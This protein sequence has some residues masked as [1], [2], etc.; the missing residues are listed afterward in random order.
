MPIVGG[1]RHWDKEPPDI[2]IL[3]LG[4]ASAAWTRC[5]LPDKFAPVTVATWNCTSLRANRAALDILDHQVLALQEVRMTEDQLQ[6]LAADQRRKGYDM[7]WGSTPSWH[8][9]R[10]GRQVDRQIPGVAI[11]IRTDLRYF[12]DPPS[13]GA[14]KRW[15]DCGRLMSCQILTHQGW[16]H[17]LNVY[18]PQDAERRAVMTQDIIQYMEQHTDRNICLL[19]DFNMDNDSSPIARSARQLRWR[20]MATEGA[21]AVTTWRHTTHESSI[22]SILLSPSIAEQASALQTHDIQ[23]GHLALSCDVCSLPDPE[24]EFVIDHMPA[25]TWH[26]KD[27]LAH[28]EVEAHFLAL[29]EAGRIS[30]AWDTWN[31]LCELCFQPDLHCPREKGKAPRLRLSQ[32][33]QE[34]RHLKG[35]IQRW[36]H[37][38]PQHRADIMT[39]W[40]LTQQ[41]EQRQSWSDWR[42]RMKTSLLTD[43]REYYAWLRGP[44]RQPSRSLSSPEGIT[45]TRRQCLNA[46]KNYWDSIT[47]QGHLYTYAPCVFPMPNSPEDMPHRVHLMKQ[48]IRRTNQHSAM[49]LDDWRAAEWKH[50]PNELIRLFAVLAQACLTFQAVPEQW[51]AVRIALLPKDHADIPTP[52]DYRPL[53]IA[54]VAYRTYAKWMLHLIPDHVLQ[55]LPHECAG[56]IP[57]RAAIL[58]WY[59]VAIEMDIA[60]DTK[61]RPDPAPL[62]G[63]AID[64]Y[65]FFDHVHLDKA[66]Q[67]MAFFGVPKDI[68]ASWAHWVHNHRRYYSFAGTIHPQ[69]TRPTRGIPQGCP[70]SMLA[71]NCIMALWAL[72]MRDHPVKVHT[73]VD[74]RIITATQPQQLQDAV[75][76]TEHF[77][78]QNGFYAR[79]K[80][81]AWTTS[82]E[83]IQISWQDA[84]PL[85]RGMAKYLGLPLCYHTTSP[86]AWFRQLVTRIVD[87]VA[88]ATTAKITGEHADK[89]IVTK[90]LPMLCYSAPIIRPTGDQLSRIRAAFRSLTWKNRSWAAWPLI[91]ALHKGPTFEPDTACFIQAWMVFHR[92]LRQ[93]PPHHLELWRRGWEQAHT[94]GIRTRLRGPLD[95]LR[96]DL[97]RYALEL[98]GEDYLT[99][100]HP[101]TDE[102]IILGRAADKEIKH[103]LTARAQH[104]L[105]LQAQRRKRLDGV[106]HIDVQATTHALRQM[107]AKSTSQQGRA[108]NN[109]D[110]WSCH[111][112]SAIRCQPYAHS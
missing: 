24:E 17:V 54:T 94:R 43:G 56:G 22:D 7:I 82:K 71:A 33:T 5:I 52:A 88:R 36:T 29:C 99:L 91:A 87:T 105:L 93:A 83:P 32:Y 50:M 75:L 68:I 39:D 66:T 44:Q 16:L 72:Q 85:P 76:A 4:G 26:A 19:G 84:T 79:K 97:H 77:D 74:D 14:L 51:L 8:R 21:T 104:Y 80:S 59:S 6:G 25:R 61:D 57:H 101:D 111:T 10:L 107:N 27:Y 64:T 1:D 12:P 62:Y 81:T 11:R 53:T 106:Q 34:Q 41:R 112:P 2:S 67:A 47:G 92:H 109:I 3:L 15:Y 60:L 103:F 20:N 46:I 110:R 70:I 90:L 13:M 42:R 45:S 28:P 55:G 89:V 38:D 69:P 23:K 98:Q 95:F 100:K 31:H 63:V 18:F 86:T 108:L 102:Y 65:K 58:A 35:F 37:A 73:F 9:T 49:G 40:W 96:R 78:D 30:E 48:I